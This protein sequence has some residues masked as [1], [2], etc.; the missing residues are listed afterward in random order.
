M[1]GSGLAA[2]L[3]LAVLVLAAGCANVPTSGLLQSTKQP[4]GVGGEQ[5]GSDCCGLVM[6][7]PHDGWS[8]AQVV[9]NFI[10]ASAD[11]ADHRAVAREYLTRAASASWQPGPGPAVTVIAQPPTPGPTSF[12]FGSRNRPT[13]RSACRCWARS[14]RAASTFPSP[15]GR[16]SSSR[17]SP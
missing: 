1:T 7:G 3:A 12:P 2:V 4:S 8:P 6:K 16:R 9:L 15:A 5:Q 10:L 14:P 11:F 13:S 17:G